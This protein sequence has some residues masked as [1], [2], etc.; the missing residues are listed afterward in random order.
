MDFV[1]EM[2]A[3]DEPDKWSFTRQGRSSPAEST[4]TMAAWHNVLT[5]RLALEY[6]LYTGIAAAQEVVNKWK[7]R[8]GPGLRPGLTRGGKA[9]DAGDQ[10]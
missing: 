5:G 6:L 1:L 9:L 3:L 8:Q 4:E 7:T 10:D 2:A